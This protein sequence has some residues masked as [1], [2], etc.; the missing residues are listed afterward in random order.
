MKTCFKC[1]IAKPR[2]EFYAH[3]AMSD[4]R[5]G[6]CKQCTRSDVREHRSNNLDRIREYDRA[7]GRSSRARARR[8]AYGATNP[9]QVW[10]SRAVNNRVRFRVMRREASCEVCGA[11]DRLRLHHDDYMLPFVVRVLC[12]THHRLWHVANGSGAN[13][14]PS[15]M[16]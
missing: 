7:R 12:A 3:R 4:G 2:D 1:G 8:D 16:F 10:A 14:L 11:T 5:L 13:V 6:K 15:P 9:I